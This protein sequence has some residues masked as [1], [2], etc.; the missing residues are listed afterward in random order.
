MERETGMGDGG[1][2][3]AMATAGALFLMVGACGP[4]AH[5]MAGPSGL[6]PED[7]DANLSPGARRLI[8]HA[9]AD[10]E[11][12][13]LRDHHVHVLGL[14]TGGT[15]TW[16]NP[17]LLTWSSPLA[18]F[19][20]LVY[21]EGSG[22][23]DG[24]HADRQ[25]MER[26]VRLIRSIPGHG[27]YGLLAFDYHYHEDGTVDRENSVFHVPNDYVVR[28]AAE[29]P[30]LFFP[31]VSV[32]PYRRDAVAALE[33]WAAEGVRLV[34]W[35]PNVQGMDPSTPRN[36]PFYRALKTHRMALLTHVGKEEAVD[37]GLDQA[38]GNP[39]LYRRPLDM[40]VTVIMAHA[41]SLGENA[42]LDR[43]GEAASN[44]DL[45]LRLMEDPR[46]A[47]TLF[48]DISAITQ[49]NRIPT[50]LTRL[51]ERGD[52]HPRLIDGSDYPLPA[53]DVVVQTS[54]LARHGLLTDEEARYLDEIF[55]YNPLLFDYVVK[56]TVRSP[57]TG[58]RLPAAI[59]TN[60]GVHP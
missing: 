53:I 16:V 8:E 51:L 56:R 60:R 54:A 45:V 31:I 25:Y 11:P 10:V 28:L 20:T 21:L 40:G 33:R 59:F 41:G 34:K 32:H 17:K 30:D 14:G 29:Y 39:L 46:Y 44:F 42:D 57:R 13:A 9:F 35:L 38:L 48:A 15:G 23:T 19:K 26:L 49:V 2:R 7:M 36:D 43:P 4:V 24:P 55:A 5:W 58:G 37:V 52:L 50:A 12:G 27:K 3:T 18:K 22:V 47:G 1:R 6:A